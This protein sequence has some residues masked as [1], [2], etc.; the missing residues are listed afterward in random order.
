M[1][2]HFS[3]VLC[4]AHALLIN[5]P[6]QLFGVREDGLI[7]D[8]DGLDDLVDVGLA[9]DLV[10]QIWSGHQRRPKAYGQVP[11]VHHVLVTVLRETADR[12]TNTEKPKQQRKCNKLKERETRTK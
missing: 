5:G 3:P 11:G 7:V 12:G 6:F 1:Q 2:R 10:Q 8:D 9:G 4:T